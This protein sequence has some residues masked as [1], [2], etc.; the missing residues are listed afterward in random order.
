[1]S[2]LQDGDVWLD[3]QMQQHGGRTV[4]Y[5]RGQ[6]ESSSFTAVAI[7][8]TYEVMDSNGFVTSVSMRDY[9]LPSASLVVNGATVTPRRGDWVRETIGGVAQT[10]EVAPLGDKDAAEARSDGARWLVHTKRVS[11]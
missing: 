1:M 5:V 10:F 4:T 8:K 9:H 7:E 11:E 6:F 3:D 2:I